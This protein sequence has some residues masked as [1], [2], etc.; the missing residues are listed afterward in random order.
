MGAV[1]LGKE[2]RGVWERVR[3]VPGRGG[4]PEFE[5]LVQWEPNCNV[6][7]TETGEAVVESAEDFNIVSEAS[8]VCLYR[9]SSGVCVRSNTPHQRRSNFVGEWKGKKEHVP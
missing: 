6:N 5:M 4:G 8:S 7:D 9:N 3:R 2:D 1:I